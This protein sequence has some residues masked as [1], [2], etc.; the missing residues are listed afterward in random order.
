MVLRKICRE[1]PKILSEI[2]ILRDQFSRR[3]GWRDHFAM[4]WFFAV[5]K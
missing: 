3:Q 4:E 2:L 5:E 1:D